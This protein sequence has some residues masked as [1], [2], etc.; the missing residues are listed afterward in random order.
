VIGFHDCSSKHYEREK[1][2]E[3][4]Y[5]AFIES[6]LDDSSSNVQLARIRSED[7]AVLM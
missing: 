4:A 7:L 3:D 1:E 5:K 6:T 2:A